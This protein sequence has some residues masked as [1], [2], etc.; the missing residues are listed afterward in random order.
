MLTRFLA[1]KAKNPPPTES[2]VNA[3][4]IRQARGYFAHH[5]PVTP[6]EE[7]DDGNNDDNDND[8]DE[9]EDENE[10]EDADRED[11]D[12]GDED[13]QSH[14][15]A[16]PAPVTP[17]VTVTPSALATPMASA[18]TSTSPVQTLVVVDS[19]REGSAE[20]VSTPAG[21][22]TFKSLPKEVRIHIWRCVLSTA[23]SQVAPVRTWAL[24]VLPCA[25]WL[26]LG[27][28]PPPNVKLENPP[29]DHYVNTRHVPATVLTKVSK[30]ARG[31][32]LE[33]FTPIQV[34]GTGGPSSKNIPTFIW[35]DRWSDVIHFFGEQFRLELFEMAGKCAYPEIYK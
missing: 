5:Y 2:D 23:P 4:L 14:G 33:R 3:L 30:E 12:D 17:L 10:N 31:V 25:P 8:D 1:H 21:A 28:T 32:V 20:G 27:M 18:S 35:I 34:A 13:S 7:D 29:W 6:V 15:T 11:D 9:D 24:A 19:S 22:T 16:T 26:E